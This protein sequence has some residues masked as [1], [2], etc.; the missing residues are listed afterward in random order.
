ME[1]EASMRSDVATGATAILNTRP[2][3][4]A[5]ELRAHCSRASILFASAAGTA[6]GSRR[7]EATR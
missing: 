3:C 1:P 2:A 6:A 7:G 5:R 4:A